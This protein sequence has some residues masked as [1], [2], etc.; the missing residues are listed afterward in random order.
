MG[1][2][3]KEDAVHGNPGNDAL[4]S[5]YYSRTNEVGDVTSQVCTPCSVCPR[6]SYQTKACDPETHEDTE[7]APCKACGEDEYVK[8]ACTYQSDTVCE[9]CKVCDAGFGTGQTL[10]TLCSGV[11]YDEETN[12]K[13]NMNDLFVAGTDTQCKACSS[14]SDAEDKREFVQ[15]VC[16]SATDTV[17]ESCTECDDGQFISRECET[18]DGEFTLTT[19]NAECAPCNEPAENFYITRLCDKT[20]YLVDFDGEECA[21]CE[22]NQYTAEP[23]KHGSATELGDNTNCVNCEQLVNCAFHNLRCD[24]GAGSTCTGC[25]LNA[26]GNC[27]DNG[28]LGESCRWEKMEAGCDT[29]GRSYRER[30]AARGGFDYETKSNADFVLWCKDNC[31]AFETCTAFE[32]DDCMFGETKCVTAE[33]I[34]GLKDTKVTGDGSDLKRCFVKP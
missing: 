29:S 23:C 8:T 20:G 27:C 12:E 3:T 5:C 11:A 26:Y 1:S 32:V 24:S 16:K 9:P 10:E 6:G 21:V 25:E 31:D 4:Y 18:S 7:C 17:C 30:Q 14:C 28:A 13:L 33:S 15:D 34:C 2:I 22:P 19:A